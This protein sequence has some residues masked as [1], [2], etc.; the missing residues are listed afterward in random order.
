MSSSVQYNHKKVFLSNSEFQ[1]M[2]YMY[3]CLKLDHFNLLI[4]KVKYVFY[5]VIFSYVLPVCIYLDR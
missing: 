3:Y 4:E 2:V 5:L 1:E